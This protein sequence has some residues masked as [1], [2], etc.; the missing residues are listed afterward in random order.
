MLGGGPLFSVQ[1]QTCIGR[2]APIPAMPLAVHAFY[3]F[4]VFHTRSV[5]IVS[6]NNILLLLKW[7][8]S[9]I[10]FRRHQHRGRVLL[11]SNRALY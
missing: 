5:F 8:S 11:I 3:A 6:L 1:F 9:N 4:Y 2:I 10:E 7:Q